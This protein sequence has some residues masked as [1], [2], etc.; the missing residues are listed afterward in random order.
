MAYITNIKTVA[1]IG[2]GV[3]GSGWAARALANGLDVIA[4]DPGAERRADPARQ[5]RQCLA[6][7]GA[8]R[9][10][11]RRQPE[12]PQVREDRRGM[13]EGRRLHPGKRAGARGPEAQAAR[14]DHP[15]PASRT[16]SSAPR[17]RACCRPT[18]TATPSTRTAAWSAIR[19]TRSICCRWSKWSKARRRRRTPPTPRRRSMPRIGMHPLK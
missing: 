11:A 19:S 6:G 8:R 16:R 2:A 7:A 10:E 9:P 15:A 3:I 14:P 12:P 5:R 4:W 17:P 18:S 13:R 1:V